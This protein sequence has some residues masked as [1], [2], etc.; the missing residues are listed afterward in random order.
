MSEDNIV[1]NVSILLK[2]GL[3]LEQYFIL[4]CIHRQ[5]RDNLQSYVSKFGILDKSVFNNLV[6]L[7]YLNKYDG[8]VYFEKLKLTNLFY[9]DFGYEKLDHERYF[10][11]LR[12]VY[13]K[14]YIKRS[15]HQDLP[16]CRKEYK[17]I[18][19]SEETHKTILKCVKLY[20]LELESD[21]RMQ[22]IQL[23]STWLHQ[24]NFEQYY[25][26]AIKLDEVVKIE[27][28]FVDDI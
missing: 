21:G 2:T 12:E 19:D 16:R 17:N 15:L 5:S 25:E 14:K 3:S 24:R 10:K 8:D 22:W 11:E 27:R 20:L 18:V 7:G 13:P 28:G 1:I 6:Q 4:E 9:K 26:E 23:L